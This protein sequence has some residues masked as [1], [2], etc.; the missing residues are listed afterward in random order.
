[1]HE[2]GN[3]KALKVLEKARVMDCGDFCVDS[4]FED[5]LKD[6][7]TSEVIEAFRF[8][9][10]EEYNILFHDF[11]SKKRTTNARKQTWVKMKMPKSLPTV[12]EKF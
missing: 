6:F 4:C 3:Y 12:F 10:T 8:N 1:M 9:H 11:E 5:T 7:V 2:V